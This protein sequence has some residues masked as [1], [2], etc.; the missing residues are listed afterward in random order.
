MKT[1]IDENGKTCNRYN[2]MKAKPTKVNVSEKA[3]I[4]RI[5]RQLAKQEERLKTNRSDRDFVTLG[6]YYIVNWNRNCVTSTHHNL[7]ALAEEMG[8]LKPWEEVVES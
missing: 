5:N 6:H 4:A 7:S 1:G 8:V 2:P 3:L